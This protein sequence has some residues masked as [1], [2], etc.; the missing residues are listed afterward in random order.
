MLY[1]INATFK[2]AKG[3]DPAMAKTAAEVVRKFLLEV[4]SGKNPQAAPTYM[5]NVVLAH[6]ATSEDPL[7]ISR[8]PQQYTE[9]VLEM[10][11][12]YGEFEFELEEL[13]SQGDKVYARWNQRG[14][15][16]LQLT[17]CVYRI[18]NERIV[19]YWIQ[20]DRLGLEIQKN[21]NK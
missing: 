6:Q 3:Y 4:R 5:A 1:S 18:E 17:S 21:R 14:A 12:E 15:G 11:A 16:L 7:T 8:T 9:H 20:I 2:T 19:E 13:F 10:K